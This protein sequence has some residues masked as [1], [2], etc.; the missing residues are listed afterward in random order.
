M[1]QPSQEGRAVKVREERT[2]KGRQRRDDGP[3]FLATSPTL[4]AASFAHDWKP[5]IFTANPE[6]VAAAAG[7]TVNNHYQ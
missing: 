4:L 5:F 7:D 6:L 2:E 3:V 1:M